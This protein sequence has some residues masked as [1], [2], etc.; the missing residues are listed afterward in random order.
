MRHDA[1][2]SEPVV[3]LAH[4]NYVRITHRFDRHQVVSHFVGAGIQLVAKRMV[5]IHG[6]HS[7]PHF[8]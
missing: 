4:G 6:S 1:R 5:E 2:E 7:R 3:S 8:N